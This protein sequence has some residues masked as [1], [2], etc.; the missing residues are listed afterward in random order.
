[1]SI[2]KKVSINHET[3][4][5]WVPR[6][7]TDAGTVARSGSSRTLDRKAKILSGVRHPTVVSD[8]SP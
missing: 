5:R 3:L 6:I 2:A 8:D 4:R 1:M 7:E